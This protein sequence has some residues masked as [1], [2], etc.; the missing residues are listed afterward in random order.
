MLIAR[1][2]HWLP[3]RRPNRSMGFIC[4]TCNLA[5]LVYN[6]NYV[7]PLATELPCQVAQDRCLPTVGRTNYQNR[8]SALNQSRGKHALHDAANTPPNAHND[9]NKPVRSSSNATD[10]V[11][12]ARYTKPAARLHPPF[13]WKYL[14]IHEE[15]HLYITTSVTSAP[16]L[17]ISAPFWI[18]KVHTTQGPICFSE[19]D[20]GPL[21]LLQNNLIQLSKFALQRHE[22]ELLLSHYFPWPGVLAK[23]LQQDLHQ[24]RTLLVQKLQHDQ[25]LLL[26]V[27]VVCRVPLLHLPRLSFQRRRF[28]WFRKRRR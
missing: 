14:G 23:L 18:E 22:I 28:R 27:L 17:L 3:P 2:I 20:L 6:H 4:S 10:S 7:A 13:S 16:L 19:H 21:A 1:S 24:L 15:L 12:S 26:V 8:L 5:C 9:T 11:K 25:K